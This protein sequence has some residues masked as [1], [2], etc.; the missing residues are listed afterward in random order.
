MKLINFQIKEF[1]SVFDS[2]PVEVGDITCLV[3]KNE[4]GKTAILQAL[5]KLNPIVTKAARYSV[6]DDYPRTEVKDYEFDVSNKKRNPATVATAQFRLD[7]AELKSF[8]ENLGKGAF[9]SDILTLSRGYAGNMTVDPKLDESLIFAHL[10]SKKALPAD[11]IAKL[12]AC[13]D[14]TQFLK[15]L[16]GA[17][18]TAAVN[19]LITLFTEIKEARG[20]L[21]W[22][23]DKFIEPRVPLFL[24]FDEY[25]QLQG[26]SN[27]QSLK[28]RQE[29]DKLLDSDYPL[30]GLISTARLSFDELINPKRTRELKNTLQA[31]SVHLT[32]KIISYWSQNKYIQ[33]QFDVRD[34]R[35]EDPAGMKNGPNIWGEVYDSKHFVTTEMATRSRGFVWF[36]SFLAWYSWCDSPPVRHFPA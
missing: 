16:G 17:E 4:A 10:I 13:E 1:R 27:L 6:I 15:V 30:L 2:T 9:T 29:Q 14:E 12:K 20:L 8:E 5:Y 35:P 26:C 11:L 23:F 33:L 36:F 34:G 3:G 7:P 25:Y 32:K 28:E 21:L 24:Y 19:E 18:R 22:V 31:A